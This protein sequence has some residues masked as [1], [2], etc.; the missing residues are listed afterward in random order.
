MILRIEKGEQS[1]EVRNIIHELHYADE[2]RKKAGSHERKSDEQS[3]QLDF[4]MS[5]LDYLVS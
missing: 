4:I 1:T 2:G 5:R 3:V